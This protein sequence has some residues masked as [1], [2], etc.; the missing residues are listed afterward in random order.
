MPRIC[1]DRGNNP[2]TR[3]SHSLQPSSSTSETSVSIYSSAAFLKT[4]NISVGETT[5]TMIIMR[6]AIT[7][8]LNLTRMS[9]K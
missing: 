6:Y 7:N 3:H 1:P 8:L 2:H 5:D 9:D 4:L